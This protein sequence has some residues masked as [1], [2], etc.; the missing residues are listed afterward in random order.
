MIRERGLKVVMVLVGLLFSAGIY[1]L[2]MILWQRNRSQYGD[3]MMLSLYFT[4]GIFLLVAVRN[5]SANASLIA[6]TAWSS[7]AHGAVMAVLAYQIPSE[8]GE[9]LVAVAALALIAVALIALA[10]P[11]QSVEQVPAVGM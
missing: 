3:A 4:L 10:P 1:P 5:P 11:K 7:F 9:F 8:R 2:T 6:F